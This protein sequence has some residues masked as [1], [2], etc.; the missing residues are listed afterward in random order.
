MTLR[1]YAIQVRGMSGGLAD[2]YQPNRG[3]QTRE[4]PFVDRKA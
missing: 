2:R 4:R 1:G 3:A